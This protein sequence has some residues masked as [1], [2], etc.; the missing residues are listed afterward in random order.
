MKNKIKYLTLFM[1]IAFKVSAVTNIV[2]AENFYGELAHEIGGNAVNVQS[3]ISNPDADPHLFTTSPA[4]STALS[5]ADIIIYN[6]AN[7]DDWIHDMLANVDKKKVLII[8]V[9]ELVNVKPGQNP[10]L[11]YKSDAFPLLAKLLAAKLSKLEPSHASVI[12]QNLKVFLSEHAQVLANINTVKSK[13]NGIEVTATEPVYG[14]M[15]SSMGL[16][17]QGLDF[18][19]KIMN[20]TEPSPQMVANYEN[21]L[22]K[23]EVKV[24]FYNSQVTDSITSNMKNLATK[25]HIQIVGVTETMPSNMKINTWLNNE[26]NATSKALL[27]S[28]NR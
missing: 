18:Q 28:K 3:I 6:G 19:W 2:A 8:N 17:M 5:H 12:N 9:A 23:K 24:L 26:V 25:N 15:A 10:H 14:Y 16:K 11:W 27:N 21:M 20:N 13:Y 4:T 1:A 22:N 7:Y